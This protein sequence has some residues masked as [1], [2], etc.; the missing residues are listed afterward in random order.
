M[1]KSDKTVVCRDI[2]GKE[3]TVSVNELRFRPSV[4]AVIVQDGK[5]LLSKQWDGYDFPGGKIELGETIEEALV[6]EVKEETGFEVKVE[7]LLN[8]FT[9]FFRNPYKKDYVQSI[10]M[11]YQCRVIGGEISTEFFDGREKEYMQAAEWIPIAEAKKVKFYN[12]A[13]NV[14]L[15]AQIERGLT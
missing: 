9:S 2:D 12:S 15:L 14:A 5:V 3:Y 4:Y 11:Y 7:K 6:R 10:L 13:D 1:G 8:N